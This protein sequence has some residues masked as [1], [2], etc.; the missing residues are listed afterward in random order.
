[1]KNV[2][3]IEGNRRKNPRETPLLEYTAS[4]NVQPIIEHFNG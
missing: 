4:L 1:M 3:R 2:N